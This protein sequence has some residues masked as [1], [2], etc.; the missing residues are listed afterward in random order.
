MAALTPF[1]YAA[2][3]SAAEIARDNAIRDEMPTGEEG[4]VNQ[5]VG[6]STWARPDDLG[7]LT[8]PTLVLHGREDRLVPVANAFTLADAIPGARL[9]LLDDCSHQIFTDQE[10][11]AAQIVLRA[12]MEAPVRASR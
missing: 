11:R 4:Y 6:V 1:I 2:G 9:E 10:E 3:T 5:L 12:F 8:C 7:S